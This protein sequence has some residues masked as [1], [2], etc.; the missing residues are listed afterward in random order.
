[1]LSYS[2]LLLIEVFKRPAFIYLGISAF[3]IMAFFSGVMYL[4]EHST[5]PKFSY[6]LDAIYFT[7]STM[8]ANGFGDIVPI[9]HLGK[10]ISM[11]MML[12][13]TFIFV[14][15]TGVVAST[16][17]ELELKVQVRHSKSESDSEDSRD[18]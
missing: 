3:T 5:N 1:M 10:M 15:F 12:L 9:T 11:V 13:G 14:S 6:F 16:V 4:V 2:K 17:L 7:V 8:T 18:P